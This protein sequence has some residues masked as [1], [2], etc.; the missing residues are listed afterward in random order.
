MLSEV[1][2]KSLPAIAKVCGLKNEQSLHHF[3]TDAPWSVVELRQ[4]RLA[5]IL[6]VGVP[7]AFGPKTTLRN[8]WARSANDKWIESVEKQTTQDED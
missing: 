6:Q 3:L 1:K 5:L 7:V 2:R 8:L 4:Q